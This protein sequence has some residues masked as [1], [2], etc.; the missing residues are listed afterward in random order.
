LPKR[1]GGATS[2]EIESIVWNGR[3]LVAVLRTEDAR[4]GYTVPRDF[5]HTIPICNDAV[6]WEIDRYKSDIFRRVQPLLEPVPAPDP[7]TEL[8]SSS[9][10]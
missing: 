9:G 6:S 5:I 1:I 8:S 3:Q 2:L 10:L 4:L 7:Q